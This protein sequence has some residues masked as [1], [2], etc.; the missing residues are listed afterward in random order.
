MSRNIHAWFNKKSKIRS[1]PGQAVLV[2]F[3]L[4][5]WGHQALR[6]WERKLGSVCPQIGNG[7]GWVGLYKVKSV[8]EGVSMSLLALSFTLL[9]GES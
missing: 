4:F 2:D 7:C 1:S 3:K 5:I 9:R 6:L 8:C